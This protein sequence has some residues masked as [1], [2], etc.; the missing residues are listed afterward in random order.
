MRRRRD[1]K[2]LAT[3]VDIRGLQRS[4]AEAAAANAERALLEREAQRANCQAELDRSEA[5]WISSMTKGRLVLESSKAWATAILKGVRALEIA[6]DEAA[7]A[8]QVQIDQLSA[9]GSAMAAEAAAE[10]LAVC[11]RR[12]ARRRHEEQVLNEAADA[13]LRNAAR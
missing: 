8:R 1:P 6:A 4:G 7:V 10:S 9:L 5:D 3:L 11:A 12:D 2:T 13:F